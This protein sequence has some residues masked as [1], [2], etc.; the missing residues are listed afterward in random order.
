MSKFGSHAALSPP[1]NGQ[2]DGGTG[3]SAPRYRK[4][5]GSFRYIAD[6]IIYIYWTIQPTLQHILSD[7]L[8]SI[9]LFSMPTIARLLQAAHKSPMDHATVVTNADGRPESVVDIDS[10]NHVPRIKRA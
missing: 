7:F 9:D 5:R 10:D 2:P 4:L 6:S 3:N 8:V 1:G